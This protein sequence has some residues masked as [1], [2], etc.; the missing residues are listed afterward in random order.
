MKKG[1]LWTA[2]VGGAYLLGS[3]SWSVLIVRRRLGIDIREVG[4]GNAG[5]TNVLRTAGGGAAAAVLVLDVAKGAAPVL[6]GRALGMPGPVV[7]TAATAAVVGHIFPVFAPFRERR[8]RGGKGV[9][10]V[11]GAMICLSPVASAMGVGVFGILVGATGYVSLGSIV[12]I[13]LF[14]VLSWMASKR[15]WSKRPAPGWLL[16]ASV[17]MGALVI[18]RHHENIHRLMTGTE[19]KLGRRVP[20]ARIKAEQRIL[21]I[22]PTAVRTTGEGDGDG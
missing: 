21:D 6:A 22:E 8:F 13:A 17:A 14:P 9:A 4:S 1:L 19:H 18:A 16:E 2:L 7:G 5:A 12:S 15:G 11:S 20:W 10:T 3:V